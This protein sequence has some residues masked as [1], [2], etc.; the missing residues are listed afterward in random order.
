MGYYKA[1]SRYIKDENGFYIKQIKKN[2]FLPWD[3]ITTIHMGTIIPQ[4]YKKVG[5]NKYEPI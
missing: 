4:L 2:Y 5:Y 1:R 3:T